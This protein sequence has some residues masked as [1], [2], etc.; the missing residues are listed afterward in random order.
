MRH[1]ALFS[2]LAL[3]LL[4]CSSGGDGDSA[5]QDLVVNPS[6]DGKDVNL[7]ITVPTGVADSKYTYNGTSDVK[8]NTA[9]SVVYA[10]R[11]A[12]GKTPVDVKTISSDN[13]AL[14]SAT[15][16]FSINKGD[17]TIALGAFKTTLTRNIPPS[18]LWMRFGAFPGGYL[19]F[20]DPNGG[21]QEVFGSKT[22]GQTLAYVSQAA[23]GEVPAFPGHY[24]WTIGSQQSS[25]FDVVAGQTA[26]P[27]IV[28]PN[29][30]GVITLAADPTPST[31]PSA[32]NQQFIVACTDSA[33]TAHVNAAPAQTIA[34]FS[35][36]TTHCSYGYGAATAAFDLPSATNYTAQL[37]N[38]D[39]DDV[40]LSDSPGQK[41]SGKYTVSVGGAVVVG[42]FPTRTS[43]AFPPGT[44]TI[45][46]TYNGA[47]GETHS[48]TNTVTL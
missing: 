1:S 12:D 33:T 19:T 35:M 40:T 15:A 29:W 13:I 44:Y 31:F 18:D 22:S 39:V 14:Y 4:A 38:L 11:A 42:P 21:T 41:A 2:F 45:T 3:T 17:D 43:V 37:K 47:A 30:V 23:N 16:L 20:I 36:V 48:T 34:I 25:E 26:T 6:G 9:T 28:E 5:A 24:V 10:P 46:T 7:T 8:P 32:T 27:T